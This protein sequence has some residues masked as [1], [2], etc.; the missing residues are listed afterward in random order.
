MSGTGA[1]T[2]RGGGALQLTDAHGFRGVTFVEAG[3]LGLDGTLAGSVNVGTGATFRANGAIGGALTVLGYAEIETLVV[4]GDVTLGRGS[5]YGATLHGDGRSSL[6]IAAGRASMEDA[7]VVIDAGPGV[8]NRVTQYRVLHADGGLS[9]TARAVSNVSTLEPWLTQT[10]TTLFATLLRTDLPL[11]S[12]ATT[13]NGASIGGAIDR[14]RSTAG[15]NIAAITRELTALDD[16]ALTAALDSA[17]GEI[18][19]SSIQLMA[20][21]GET[22]STLVRDEIAGRAR[23]GGPDS[24]S[25]GARRSGWGNPHRWWTRLHGQHVNFDRVSSA[26]GGDGHLRGF[27]LGLDWTPTDRW[28]AG[29]GGGYSTGRLAIDDGSESNSFSSPRALGY[30]GYRNGRW[31]THAGMSAARTSYET[32]RAINFAAL[33]PLRDGLLFGG[34]TREATSSPLGL[35]VETWGEQRLEMDLGSWSFVPSAGLRFARY[36]R[37]GWTENGAADLSVS[38]PAQVV[39]SRE[40]DAGLSLGRAR[41]RIQ[42]HVSGMY[43]RGLGD[44]S[45]RTLLQLSDS[46]DGIFAVDGLPLAGGTFVGRAGLV[47]RTRNIGA[48]VSYEI[49][50]GSFQ[51]RHVIQLSVGYN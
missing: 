2:K 7:T 40:V 1:V 46:S 12:F 9:G 49:Q 24:G 5:Q 39:T 29:A 44:R 21:D 42:P 22:A 18:H 36:G 16:A 10:G 32:R 41:G 25:P 28:L 14:L 43:R 11:Q 13:V 30:I 38:A 20:L 4:G 27:L 6:L 51:R 3:L 31:T 47:L 8:F 23:P 33:T 48:S 45:T 19:A 17:A 26:H 15:G 35:T 34:V 37:G 50:R